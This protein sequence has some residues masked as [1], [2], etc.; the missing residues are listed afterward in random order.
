M[1]FPKRTDTMKDKMKNKIKADYYPDG[2]ALIKMVDPSYKAYYKILASWSGGYLDGDSWKMSSEIT[3]IKEDD[4]NYYTIGSSGSVYALRKNGRMPN[5]YA[6]G[7]FQNVQEQ[8]AKLNPPILIELIP[9]D[10]P[11][12]A[13]ILTSFKGK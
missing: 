11:E 10:D 9:N 1:M 8:A 2:W 12:C 3:S 4:E 6:Y 7:V 5:T 13:S